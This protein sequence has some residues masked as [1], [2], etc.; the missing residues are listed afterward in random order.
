MKRISDG[1]IN[2]QWKDRNIFVANIQHSLSSIN[3]FLEFR[4]SFLILV[5][6]SRKELRLSD[7]LI[8]LLH[9]I[10]QTSSELLRLRNRLNCAQHSTQTKFQ[11]KNTFPILLHSNN[12]FLSSSNTHTILVCKEF[13]SE[14]RLFYRQH[15]PQYNH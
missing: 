13:A 2:L 15:P 10:T 1:F 11:N 5:L 7:F 6:N 14:L 3:F 9:L 4:I 8:N 12:F